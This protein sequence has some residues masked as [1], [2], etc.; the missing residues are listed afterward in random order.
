M[1]RWSNICIYTVCIAS[2]FL[3]IDSFICFLNNCCIAKTR[4][5]CVPLTLAVPSP[6]CNKNSHACMHSMSEEHQQ[7]QGNVTVFIKFRNNRSA[8]PISRSS[9]S[10]LS[11]NMHFFTRKN[12]TK[13]QNSNLHQFKTNLCAG[14]FSFM[15]TG[16][17]MHM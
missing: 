10:Y 13:L 6:P 15:R 14:I 2:E 3:F 17:A 8:L 7:K 5:V 9:F 1:E 4:Q 16:M 11:K 12:I